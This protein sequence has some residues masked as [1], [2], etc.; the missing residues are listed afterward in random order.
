MRLAVM[1]DVHANLPA[2]RAALDAV[3]TEGCDAVVHTGDAIAIG[4]HP[5]EC[6]DLLLQAPG[7][8]LVMG[9]HD[10]WFAF[11]LPHPRPTWMT[12][13]EVVHQLWTHAQLDP[14][15]RA[16]VGAWPYAIDEEIEGVRV[17]FAHYGLDATGQ[18]LAPFVKRPAPADLDAMFAATGAD[19]VCYGHDHEPL[20]L[21]GAARYVNPG[22]LGCSREP[23]ARF[24]IVE[25]AGGRFT[26]DR[27][28]VPYDDAG[29]LRAFAERKVPERDFILANFFGRR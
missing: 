24:A 8:R 18:G 11:G 10:A 28:A 21:V 2:L 14:A 9:N 27:R 25:V 22:A 29:L 7:K 6:L 1:T 26:V 12:E 4:P 13:G 17:H 15:L 20:D 3:E 16:T 23:V 5:A 19:L